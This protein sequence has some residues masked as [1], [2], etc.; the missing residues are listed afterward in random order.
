ME[1]V[2]ILVKVGDKVGEGDVVAQVEAMKAKHDIKSPCGGTVNAV[3]V[4][5]G[6]EIDSTKPILT[7]G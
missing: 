3:L 4:Q 2:D 5:I 1:V 6:D 7:I